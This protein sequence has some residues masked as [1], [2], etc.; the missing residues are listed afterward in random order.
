M[1]IAVLACGSSSCISADKATIDGYYDPPPEKPADELENAWGPGETAALLTGT[2]SSRDRNLFFNL[3]TLSWYVRAQHRRGIGILGGAIA[4]DMVQTRFEREQPVS[5]RLVSHGPLGLAGRI[6]E[7][8]L[9][10]AGYSRSHWFFPFYRYHNV[11]G[12]RAFYPLFIFPIGLR[13][14]PN[15]PSYDTAPWDQATLDPPEVKPT[16]P[17]PVI[18][19]PAPPLNNNELSHRADDIAIRNPSTT[20][21]V[22]EN[23]TTTTTPP[24][25]IAKGTWSNS[26]VTEGLTGPKQYVVQ[27]GDT[28]YKIARRYY[29]SGKE[30]KKIYE[31][32]RGVVSDPN[33]LAPGMKLSIPE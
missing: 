21:S 1:L 20:N 28:F 17:V 33:K 3:P 31:A 26:S 19:R 29:G 2:F 14:D 15:P 16:K 18:T 9:D 8:R 11:N 13:D 27:K 10:G 24:S 32:N 6:E 22:T 5:R 25:N 23:V 30:W 4:Y 7:R 12:Q